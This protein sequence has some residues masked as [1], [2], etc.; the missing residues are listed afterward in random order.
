MSNKFSL[1]AALLAVTTAS[2]WVAACSSNNATSSTQDSGTSSSSSSGGSGSSSGGAPHDSGASDAHAEGGALGLLV[3]NMS[4]PQG[5]Q[6]SLMVPTGDTPG[7]Y[8]TY[9]DIPASNYLLMRSL[10]T[11]TSQLADT[12][13]SPPVVNADGSQITGELCFGGQ[14]VGYAGLGMSFVYAMNAN[15]EAGGLSSPTPFNASHYSGLSFYIK[16]DPSD[17]S[18]ATIHFGVPDTQTADVVAWPMTACAIGDAGGCDDDF[19]SDLAVTPGMWTKVS[20]KWADLQQQ[21]WGAQFP[22]IKQD[23][24]IGMKWQANG[25]GA[26]A[27]AESFNFCISEIYFTP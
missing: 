17:G 12:P 11:G 14:V 25:S 6:I 10:I 9:S 13:V 22:V 21:S 26:D 24:L 15:A 23:Q 16:V 3:D 8:Y 27:A 18:A 20:L 5:T 4:A 2:G 19:G 7:T 1:V